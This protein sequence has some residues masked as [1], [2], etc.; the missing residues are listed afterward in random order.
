[1]KCKKDFLELYGCWSNSSAQKYDSCF[2]CWQWI[3]SLDCEFDVKIVFLNSYVIS[4]LLWILSDFIF[5]WI[6]GFNCIISISICLLFV[7]KGS[8]ISL[9]NCGDDVLRKI[10]D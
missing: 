6:N 10:S 9:Y 5:V 8:K 3:D 1:M 4:K 2:R 7:F